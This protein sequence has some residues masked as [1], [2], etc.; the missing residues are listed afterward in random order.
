[1]HNDDAGKI[2]GV[3]GIGG[4]IRTE[5]TRCL[6]NQSKSNCILTLNTA[7][8]EDNTAEHSGSLAQS[9][10]FPVIVLMASVHVLLRTSIY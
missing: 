4:E 3:T 1:M 7:P 2:E 9:T 10:S 5:V 6:G 8:Y